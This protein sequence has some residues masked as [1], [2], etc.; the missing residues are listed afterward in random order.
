MKIKVIRTDDVARKE[1]GG[2]SWAKELLTETTVNTKKTML[3]ISV[4]K[5]GADTA[6]MTH[7]EEELCYIL[8]GN[9][10]IEYDKEQIRVTEGV[11]LYIPPGAVHKVK[12]LSKID[13]VMIYVFSYPKYPSTTTSE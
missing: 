7:E 9:G 6:L 10:I 2:G 3:G 11:A 4:F 13:L 1:L 8:H 5:P 12:N